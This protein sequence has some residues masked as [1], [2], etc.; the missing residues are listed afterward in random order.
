[1]AKQTAQFNLVHRR[2]TKVGR[3]RRARRFNSIVLIRKL[4]A[5]SSGQF[6]RIRKR[7]SINLQT[8]TLHDLDLP[9]GV[10]R[11]MKCCG[12]R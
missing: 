4:Y 7:E 1:M 2:G 10:P 8:S 9:I 6:P 12:S 5:N 11:E 3:A